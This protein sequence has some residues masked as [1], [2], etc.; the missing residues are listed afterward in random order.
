MRWTGKIIGAFVG[1]LGGPVGAAIG[2]IIG[3]RYDMAG[4]EA[5]GAAD[6]SR[7]GAALFETSFSVMG[8]L[9][10]ADGRVSEAEI[11]AARGVMRQMRLDPQSVRFAVLAYTRGKNPGYPLEAELDRLKALCA[12]RPDVLRFFVEMQIRAAIAGN[13]LGGHVRAELLRVGERLGFT[14]AEIAPL[15]AWL[16]SEA[17]N[18]EASTS[19]ADPLSGAYEILRVPASASDADVKKAYRRQMSENHPD[20]L[21]ARGLPES[22]Q[23][24][25]KQKTQRIREAYELIVERRGVR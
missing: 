11:A 17:A 19:R 5:A 3:H 21:A 24:L 20:K 13:G 7:I 4:V 10:K 18:G 1:L 9:A 23:E 16:R 12:N 22:M 15:E 2:A 8:Y 6:P 25:A 14:V